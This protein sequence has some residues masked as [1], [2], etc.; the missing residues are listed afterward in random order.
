MPRNAKGSGTIRKRADGRW[1]GKYTLGVDPGT[2]KQVR[3]SVYGKT[4]KQVAEKLRRIT[5][6]VDQGTHTEPSKL[7]VG[8]WLDVWLSEYTGHL[9]EGTLG[10]YTR[11][12]KKII[13]PKLGAVKLPMLTKAAVQSFINGLQK[14]DAPL[15]PKSVKNV[16]GV[17]HKALQQ[18]VE[19]DYIRINP[20]T[21]CK[22]PRVEKVE[23]QPLDGD[24][25]ALF[26]D[27][28]QGHPFEPALIVDVFTGMRQGELLGLTWDCVD[29]NAGT[30]TLRRQLQLI[31]GQ[32]KFTSLKNDKTRRITPASLV[33]ATL[34]EQRRVQAEWRLLAGKAWQDGGFVFTNQL[35]EHLARQT[36][37]A[38]FKRIAASIGLPATRF[39]DLRHTAAVTAI[40]AGMDIKSVQ[41]MLGHHTAAF[42]LDQY[43]H[44][45]QA[46]EN[47]N[48]ARMDA[49]IK[50]ITTR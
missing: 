25:L 9:K 12:A 1:E 39:H 30:I 7:T 34:R 23:M 15:C 36:L 17:L 43:G 45:T 24:A 4:Q 35:G 37:Y 6:E 11:H 41:A 20:A 42:T 40:R 21:A 3:K 13:A 10:L 5:A 2:G 29:F 16:H 46:M 28:I 14:S 31:G 49:F 8:A 48:A 38:A 22:L 50:S 19:L 33:I 32:Y 18:A 47:E 44:V 26:L 27:A